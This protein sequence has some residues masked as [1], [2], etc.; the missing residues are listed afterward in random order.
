MSKVLHSKEDILGMAHL[1]DYLKNEH[2]PTVSA[3]EKS[4]YEQILSELEG[5]FNI[6]LSKSTIIR[7]CNFLRKPT[8]ISYKS[9][10]DFVYWCFDREIQSFRQLIKEREVEIESNNL[11]TDTEIENIL[12]NLNP[13][14]SK[15]LVN[16]PLTIELASSPFQ[17]SLTEGN[18]SQLLTSIAHCTGDILSERFLND[19]ELLK[20]VLPDTRIASRIFV[21]QQRRQNNIENI[22]KKAIEFCRENESNP[23]AEVDSDWVADFFE[24]AKDTSNEN[25]Q[26]IWAKILANEVDKPGSF[27]RRAI[28]TVKLISHE[29]ASIFNLFCNCMWEIHPNETRAEKVLIKIPSNA[30]LDDTVWGFDDSLIKLMVDLGLVYEST[31]HITKG[32]KC[33]FRYFDYEHVLEPKTDTISLNLVHLSLIGVELYNVVQL[34]KNEEYYDLIIN[35]VYLKFE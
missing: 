20:S 32:E 30:D 8:P 4:H 5:D 1:L 7:I 27:S 25:M 23:N 15:S 22:V 6:T 34:E 12:K 16:R 26:Y 24:T 31:L 21:N 11:V 35:E 18:V 9:L 14:K 3:L 10:D 13:S 2:F 29:E 19:P 28:H 17:L 33:A